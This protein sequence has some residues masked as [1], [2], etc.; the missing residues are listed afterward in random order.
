MYNNVVV[1]KNC[2]ITLKRHAIILMIVDNI[3][4]ISQSVKF[5]KYHY[6]SRKQERTM[7]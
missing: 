3:S 1:T 2:E 4:L 6:L 5:G 7:I